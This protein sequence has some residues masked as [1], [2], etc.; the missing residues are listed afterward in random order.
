MMHPSA[1]HTALVYQAGFISPV[2]QVAHSYSSA[3]V[4]RIP[5]RYLLSG[6]VAIAK[7]LVIF[8]KHGVKSYIYL[9][10][11]HKV[12]GV[13]KPSATFAASLEW[14][15]VASKVAFP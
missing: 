14:F 9:L 5:A 7:Y 13:F 1:S 2:A 6:L 12:G 4:S 15:V 11:F 10:F 8:V 3:S